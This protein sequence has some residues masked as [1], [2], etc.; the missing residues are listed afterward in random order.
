MV[1]FL[2]G[3]FV[4]TFGAADSPLARATVSH[5]VDA[6][7]TSRLYAL[8]GM[9]EV[10]GS[11]I[12]G[13]ALAVFF[14]WGLRKKGLWYGLPWFYIAFLSSV[15]LFALALV[16]PPKQSQEDETTGSEPGLE[17]YAQDEESAPPRQG[18][19]RI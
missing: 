7:Y 13:P 6:Q 9:V 4:S 1:L 2:F 17:N 10:L 5:Y 15:A 18:P 8:I 19:I 14:D 11:F 16:R 12:G 3:L